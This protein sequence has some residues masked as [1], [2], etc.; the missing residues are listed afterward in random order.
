[1]FGN[2]PDESDGLKR[3]ASRLDIELENLGGNTIWPYSFMII[4]GRN[5]VR[6]FITISR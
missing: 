6:N 4:Q 1:M 3:E 5:D 2:N